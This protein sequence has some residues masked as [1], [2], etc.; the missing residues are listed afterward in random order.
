MAHL[1]DS[2]RGRH[3]P[4]LCDSTK[5]HGLH[6][7]EG[8]KLVVPNAVEITRKRNRVIEDVLDNDHY[9]SV[10]GRR[11]INELESYQDV[12]VGTVVFNRTK[13][14]RNKCE[15]YRSIAT[16]ENGEFL[17]SK[18]NLH[19]SSIQRRMNK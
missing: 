6:N 8:K 18:K 10:G 1:E 12:I 16:I 9:R 4:P 2:P 17:Q 19:F 13:L 14:P 5:E 7:R 3:L 15:E 11:N